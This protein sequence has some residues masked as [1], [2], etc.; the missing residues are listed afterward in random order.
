MRRVRRRA[1]VAASALMISGCLDF[2]GLNEVTD[3]VGGGDGL[4]SITIY[5]DSVIAVGDSMRVTAGGTPSGVLGMFTYDRLLDAVWAPS[6]PRVASV[7]ARLPPRGDSLSTTAALV[8]GL[9]PGTV[10][11]TAAARGKAGHL[12]V[13]VVALTAAP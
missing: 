4:V 3:T 1:L 6:D 12:T 13:H 8:R 10:Q 7:E 2:T 9:R 11:I 5:G